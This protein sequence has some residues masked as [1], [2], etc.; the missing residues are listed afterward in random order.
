[1]HELVEVVSGIEV[2]V[3][4]FIVVSREYTVD[5]ANKDILTMP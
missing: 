5:E 2:L 1:M 3:D 4:D